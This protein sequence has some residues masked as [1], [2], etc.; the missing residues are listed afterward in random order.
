VRQVPF[1]SVQEECCT[2]LEVGESRT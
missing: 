1:A 2:V